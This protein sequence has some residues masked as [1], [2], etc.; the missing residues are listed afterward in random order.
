LWASRHAERDGT[1]V[2]YCNQVGGQDEVVFDGDSFVIGPDG[3]VGARGAVCATD[4]VIADLDLDAGTCTQDGGIPPRPD[5]LGETW[6][7]LVLATRDYV[8]KNGFRD[9]WIALSGGIDSAVTAAIAVDALG[10]DAVTGVALPS[11]HS[12]EHSLTDAHGLAAN[13]GIT[14]HELPIEPAMTAFDEMLGD[15]LSEEFGLAEENLQ[16]R[17][18]GTTMMALSNERGGLVLTTGNKSEYAVGYATLYGDMNGAF[19]PLKDVPKTLVFE[20]ARWRNRGAEVIPESTITKPPSAELRPGQ[21][22]QDS[23]PPYELLDRII[24]GLIEDD[25]SVEDLVA[26][27]LDEATVREVRRLID[28]AEFK[29]R[30]S[31]PGPKITR[32][33]FGRERRVPI[34][35]GWN[36]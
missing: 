6:S 36:D 2:L 28:R 8:H 9:V 17:I 3:T 33:A 24:E 27:G 30:Q 34:T 11:P 5:P 23:L 1:F 18:R 4:L 21:L 16:S 19:G 20:L 22:D 26:E 32:R 10:P 13:L 14:C 25:A 12:S 15:L 35:N 31:A 29:R 7:A